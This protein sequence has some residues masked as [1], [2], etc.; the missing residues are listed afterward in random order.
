MRQFMRIAS[1]NINGI[2]ARR[3]SLLGW[4]D[5]KKPDILVLEEL[6]AQEKDIPEEIAAMQGYKKY[7]NDSTFR[8]GYSGVGLLLKEGLC[9]ECRFEI[10]EFD[11][12]NRTVV[13]HY[14]NLTVI[15]T[16]V[17]RGDGDAHYAVKLGYLEDLGIYIRELLQ[18]GRQIIHAGDINVAHTDLDVHR[19]QNKPGA[20]G[21]REEERAAIGRH[22]GIGLHDIMRELFPDKKDLF[23]WWPYW[24]G[25]R[26]RNLGWRIDCFY[27]SDEL[28]KVVHEASVDLGEKSSDHAPVILDLG[29]GAG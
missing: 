18:Q 8:K 26:E 22:L 13:V 11:R 28:V 7:W 19:S 5:R 9:S 23:T 27:L 15:G 12:E 2:R 14:M 24:K 25:A 4:I 10:P 16:Y 20:V 3:D 17:P 21:L 6:K 1:W 29:L